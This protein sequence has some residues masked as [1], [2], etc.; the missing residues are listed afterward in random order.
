M[1]VLDGAH[2][3]RN[4]LD[5]LLVL[6]AN[7][8]GFVSLTEPERILFSNVYYHLDNVDVI[9]FPV[10]IN[11]DVEETGCPA[12]R[13][14]ILM[15]SVGVD[16]FGWQKLVRANLDGLFTGLFVACQTCLCQFSDL[17]LRFFENSWVE[18][19]VEGKCSLG[20]FA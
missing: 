19:K 14:E 5:S 1:A 13:G 7:V 4:D 6:L 17:F 16:H 18:H 20:I 11:Q 3:V 10:P 9:T 2:Q 15:H 12:V 8:E